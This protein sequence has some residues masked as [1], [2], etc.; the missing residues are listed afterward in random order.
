MSGFSRFQGAE[1]YIADEGLLADVNAAIALR[2]TYKH[3]DAAAQEGTD[4]SAPRRFPKVGSKRPVGGRIAAAQKGLDL[5]KM[6]APLMLMPGDCT[7]KHNMNT[8]RRMNMRMHMNMQINISMNLTY[9]LGW[10]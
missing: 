3:R 10:H 9:V 4:A 6:F 5:D 7:T 2:S 1:K 8:S